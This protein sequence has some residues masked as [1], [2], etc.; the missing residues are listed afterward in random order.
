MIGHL[1]GC[2]ASLPARIARFKFEKS[3]QPFIRTHNEPL[4]VP[5][6]RVSDEDCAPAR[7]HG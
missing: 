2:A 5:A 4:T 7:I 6:M 3:R 1:F